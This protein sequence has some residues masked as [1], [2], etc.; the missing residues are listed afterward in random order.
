MASEGS[1]ADSIRAAL[2]RGDLL[3]AYDEVT[4]G[5]ELADRELHYLEVLTL[6]RLGDTDQALRLYADYRI[7]D[8]GDVDALSLKARL[9]KD[10]AFSGSEPNRAR[11]LEACG[12]YSGV[13]RQTRSTY[14][15]INAATLALIA[16]RSRLAVSMARAV[17]AQCEADA[18][19]D[20]FSL[21]TLAEALVVLGDIEA[22]SAALSHALAAP[23]A[24]AGARSTTV[25]QLQR[26]AHATADPQGVQ[27]LLELVRPQKV[28]MFCGN[29]FVE[30]AE[31]EGRL[32]AQVAQIIVDEDVGFAY[33]ALAAGSDILI[34]EQLLGHDVE[35]TVVLPFAEEDFLE[36]SVAPAGGAWLARYQAVKAR[37]ASIIFA[38]H[39]RYVDGA[40]QFGYGSKVTMGLSRLR[41]RHLNSAALQI[42][43]VEA[44]GATTLSGS[45]IS[46][47]QATGGRSAVIT[48]G[49]LQRPQRPPAP[50]APPVRSRLERNTSGL[51]FMD[52][53]GFAALDEQA[54]PLFYDEVMGRVAKVLKRYEGAIRESNSWGDAVFVVFDDAPSAA[55]SALDICERFS[56][57]DCAA[58]GVPEGTA[59]RVALHYGPTYVGYDPIRQETAHFGTEVSRAARIEPVTPS[60]S[61]YVTESFAAILEMEAAGR[62]ICNYVGKVSLAKGYGVFPLYGLTRAP[63]QAEAPAEP[64][65]RAQRA[66]RRDAAPR[67]IA[68]ARGA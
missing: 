60:G 64:A 55:A 43:I 26:L 57:V 61:V 3:A 17:V 30:D 19:S 58:L 56:E 28:A 2:A 8:L 52:Y 25:L 14:P 29:I 50:P 10:Q 67:A 65:E 9:L 32:A 66:P 4:Q 21:V 22:A 62:F 34:A 39:M 20:Y 13:Y 51:M 15:A 23:D 1:K 68:S 37:A 31:I 38:S 33:G 42:A 49:P 54:L 63:T 12:L 6:A 24:V 40:A 27:R 48:A 5:R 41:A 53:P 45:D 46:D 11:L 36:Q 47:W 16:G 35:L 44:A 7:D 18:R 59:M